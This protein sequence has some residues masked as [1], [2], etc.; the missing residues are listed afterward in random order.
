MASFH[1]SKQDWLALA[2]ALPATCPRGRR[3]TLIDELERW[4]QECRESRTRRSKLKRER[5]QARQT[6]IRHTELARL[7]DPVWQ[8]EQ[9]EWAE[10]LKNI[11]AAYARL[12]KVFHGADFDRD[13]FY[14]RVLSIWEA[15]GGRL[16][17]NSY[18]TAAAGRFLAIAAEPVLGEAP[19]QRSMPRIVQRYRAARRRGFFGTVGEVVA[20][21]QPVIAD[22]DRVILLAD[23]L[24]QQ[25]PEK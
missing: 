25:D 14:F 12:T 9:R 22:I 11:A 1:Y 15:A 3:V 5:D 19:D 7:M 21:G 13:T 4:A 23:E 17:G 2:Y 8:D 20:G 10:R 18:V 24:T 16:G 6:L